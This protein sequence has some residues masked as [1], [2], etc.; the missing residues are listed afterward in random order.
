MKKLL[1]IACISAILLSSCDL[2]FGLLS[3]SGTKRFWAVDTT[4]ETSDPKYY[5]Q[6]SADLLAENDYCKVWVENGSGVSKADAQKMAAEYIKIYNVMIDTFGLEFEVEYTSGKKGT[7]NTLKYADALTDADGKLAIL[8]LDIKDNYKKGENE[9]YV[10]GYFTPMN[11]FP[12]SNYPNSNVCDMIYIDT[13][14]GFKEKP[15]DAYSTLAHEL[16][17]LMN[18]VTT[19]EKRLVYDDKGELTDILLMDTWIDEGLASA[20][21][22]VYTG[23]HLLDRWGWYYL[24]GGG[25]GANKVTSLIDKGN[26]FFVWGN[27]TDETQ[28]AILDDYATVYLFFQ[29]LR[30]QSGKGKDIYKDII[31]SKYG[32][33]HAV[34][35]AAGSSYNNGNWE[36]LLGDWLAANYIYAPTGI[37][38][39][40]NDFDFKKEGVPITIKGLHLL[41]TKATTIS[42]YPGEGVFSKISGSNTIPA[43]SGNI[44]YSK[45]TGSD[46]PD[47]LLTYNA[48]AVNFVM[49]SDNRKKDPNPEN[50]T[51]IAASVNIADP[52]NGRAVTGGF[53][54]KGPYRIGAGDVRRGWAGSLPP[55][56]VLQL[57]LTL[58]E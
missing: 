53:S 8:L 47:A 48:N 6:L 15:E 46:I 5:Y 12:K 28:Y 36:K 24:N 29:W 7:L 4:K 52:V 1:F 38:G 40:K 30:I 49:G 17:H 51:V 14:P 31:S 25:E 43:K 20:A 9:S 34:T 50:G 23:G 57:S 44:T 39:Y 13:N 19:L 3:E 33:Y 42:L 16:Q 10:A 32:D 22:Y 2:L 26:N 11:I 27:R 35:E 54:I 58:S 45:L 18:F 55:A 21:E 41:S 56:G 37:N